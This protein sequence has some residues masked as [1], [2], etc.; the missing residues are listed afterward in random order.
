MNIH[1]N[2][3]KI[4]RLMALNAPNYDTATALAEATAAEFD[5]YHWLDNPSCDI[6]DLA[7]EYVPGD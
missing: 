5:S 2:I 3:G 1:Q 7:L 6:W 4:R